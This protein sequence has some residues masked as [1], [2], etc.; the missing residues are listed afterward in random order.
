MFDKYSG[1]QLL[2]FG[3]FAFESKRFEV[4]SGGKQIHGTTLFTTIKFQTVGTKIPSLNAIK[5]ELSTLVP[6]TII[7]RSMNFDISYTGTDRILVATVAANTNC[8][9]YESYKLFRNNAPSITRQKKYFEPNEP[10]VCSIF[11]ID[12]IPNK[13]TFG[14]PIFQSLVEFYL[15]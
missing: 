11:S 5:V 6:E 4:W 15:D 7:S 3:N 10:Y 2:N 8:E 1:V 9:N 13:V 12:N 14:I